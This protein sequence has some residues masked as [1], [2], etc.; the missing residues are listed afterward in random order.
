MYKYFEKYILFLNL[1]LTLKKTE[2]DNYRQEK[3]MSGNKTELVRHICNAVQN[4]R[5]EK[6]MLFHQQSL[7][8][9]TSMLVI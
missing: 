6:P 2:R 3:N 5:D 8:G 1:I 7:S 9:K 4:A